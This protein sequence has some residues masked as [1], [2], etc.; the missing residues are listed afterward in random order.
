MVKFT[1]SFC[2]NYKKYTR[3]SNELIKDDYQKAFSQ[4]LIILSQNLKFGPNM[5]LKVPTPL[6]SVNSDISI[7]SCFITFWNPKFNK[8]KHFIH[9]LQII[10][11]RQKH[12]CLI[13]I[14]T[15][16]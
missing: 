9:R 14:T 13:A 10:L 8:K 5:G 3:K 2:R 6:P 16:I 4:Q 15:F 7:Y 11:I 1:L 12:F